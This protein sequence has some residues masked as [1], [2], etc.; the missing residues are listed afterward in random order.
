MDHLNETQICTSIVND[1][2][3]ESIRE[4]LELAE[5]A[6][7]NIISTPKAG[8]SMMHVL[9]AF[10]SEFL[11][12]EVLVSSAE[13]T[14]DG[15]RG[16]GMVTGDEPERS[17]ARACAEVLLAGDNELLKSRV[18]KLLAS[19]QQNLHEQRRSEEKLIAG[20]KVSFELMAGQ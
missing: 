16:F 2:P 12:G 7:I 15:K 11:L 3:R 13:V 5:T 6:P 4:L 19:E 14:L 17:L 8:L 18:Q 20:T 9:D 1:M 10:D